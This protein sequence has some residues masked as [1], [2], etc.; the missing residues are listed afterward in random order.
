MHK[1]AAYRWY[2]KHRLPK[3][4]ICQAPG[5]ANSLPA[6]TLRSKYCSMKCALRVQLEQI[7]Q[8]NAAHRGGRKIK[9]LPLFD[10]NVKAEAADA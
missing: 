5:C 3:N 8:W 7:R 10:G 9:N 4:S 6:K 2:L 1:E